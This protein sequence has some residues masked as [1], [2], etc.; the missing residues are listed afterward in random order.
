MALRYQGQFD[1]MWEY[2]AVP[3]PWVIETLFHRCGLWVYHQLPLLPT[4]AGFQM[5]GF[6]GGIHEC[7]VFIL[8]FG[9][10]TFC[11]YIAIVMW[12]SVVL[13]SAV[14]IPREC[15]GCSLLAKGIKHL[16]EV[17]WCLLHF[18]PEGVYFSLFM[19]QS[20]LLLC[21]FQ[22]NKI[23]SLSSL[24]YLSELSCVLG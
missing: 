1:W 22:N 16:H 7:W 24:A 11:L 13:L 19:W 9:T 5:V 14:L 21:K 15:L 18:F 8:H 20:F 10:L 2:W 3:C 23:F 6:S 4:M 17:L 12:P